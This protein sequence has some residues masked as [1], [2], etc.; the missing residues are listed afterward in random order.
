MSDPKTTPPEPRFLRHGLLLSLLLLGACTVTNL[1]SDAGA[2]AEHPGRSPAFETYA[3][4][5]EAPPLDGTGQLDEEALLRRT[6]DAVDARLASIGMFRVADEEDAGLLLAPR[7]GIE[8]K[9]EPR[10]PYYSYYSAEKLEVGVLT[11]AFIDAETHE[12]V[13][14]EAS[15]HNLRTAARG[16]GLNTLQFVST[17]EERVWPIEQ[18]VD[19]VLTRAGLGADETAESDPSRPVGKKATRALYRRL[20]EAFPTPPPQIPDEPRPIDEK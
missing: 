5:R 3:W 12:L 14:R 18:M 16:I 13:G 2:D 11:I 1:A 19:D 9:L 10:D 7:L 6:Q 4:S 15:R 17:S 8:V 20:D